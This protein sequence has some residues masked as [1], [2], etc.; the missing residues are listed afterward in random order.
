[1]WEEEPVTTPPTRSLVTSKSARIVQKVIAQNKLAGRFDAVVTV[2]DVTQPKPHPE[3]I[4]KALDSLRVTPEEAVY[5]GD[6]MFDVDSARAAGVM[7]AGVSW[8]A[9]SKADLLLECPDRVFDTWR[10][11]VEWVGKPGRLAG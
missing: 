9:R 1:M 7:M 10:E 4:L 6:A 11:L 5:I 8:G 2:D 3:P